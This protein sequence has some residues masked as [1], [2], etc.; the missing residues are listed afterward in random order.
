MTFGKFQRGLNR[1]IFRWADAYSTVL[2]LLY[3]KI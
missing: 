3:I 1:A 2:N